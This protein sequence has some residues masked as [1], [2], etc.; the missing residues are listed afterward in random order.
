M[1]LPPDYSE[2]EWARAREAR[3]YVH[4]NSCINR[5]DLSHRTCIVCPRLV[6]LVLALRSLDER[7]RD[8]LAAR[9]ILHDYVCTR[10]PYCEDEHVNRTQAKPVVALRKFHQHWKESNEG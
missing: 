8:A 9:R 7:P 4:A 6:P 1:T 2:P 5:P 3:Q 10:A